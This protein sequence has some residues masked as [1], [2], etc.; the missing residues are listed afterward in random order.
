M[1]MQRPRIFKLL[2]WQ[3]VVWHTRYNVN[4]HYCL[5]S[6]PSLKLSFQKC[7]ST[8][9]EEAK[10]DLI[11]RMCEKHPQFVFHVL[12]GSTQEQGECHPDHKPHNEPSLT[13]CR[14]THY[15]EMPTEAE[16][17]CCDQ[18]LHNCYSR[19][20]VCHFYLHTQLEVHILFT[21]EYMTAPFH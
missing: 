2:L 6:Y 16:T 18:A 17:V 12:I 15:R 20:Q 8:L 13:W 5:I 19:L 7:I 1:F 10:D 21:L 11:R 9:T 4:V 14:Y 3:C